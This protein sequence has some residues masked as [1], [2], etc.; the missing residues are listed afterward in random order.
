LLTVFTR[1]VAISARIIA[2]AV[3]FPTAWADDM[4]Q[5]TAIPSAVRDPT[6]SSTREGPSS[7]PHSA[8]NL[9]PGAEPP[10]Q[11]GESGTVP[12]EPGDSL[13]LALRKEALAND[14][15]VGFFIALIRQE[16]QLDPLA[17]SHVGAQGIAQFMPKTAR[18]RGLADPFEPFQALHESGRWLHELHHQFGNL[19]L[20]AAAYNAGPRRVQDWIQGRAKLPDETKRYVAKITGRSAD[21]WFRVGVVDHADTTKEDRVSCDAIKFAKSGLP[22]RLRKPENP[23]RS[24]DQVEHSWGLQLIGDSSESRAM[25]EYR[26]LQIKFSDVLANRPPVVLKNQVGAKG[27]A[28]WFR[29]RITERT[30]EGATELCTKLQAKGGSCLLV[31]N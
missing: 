17:R 8:P 22:L 23:G 12:A 7:F 28:Y 1:V 3:S 31:R 26:R 21:E 29:V 15:P 2:S 18:W 5:R 20:A 24:R 14:L 16:S 19:G 27:S 6:H 9:Q 11:G 25:A 10:G 13:C 4:T 30:R